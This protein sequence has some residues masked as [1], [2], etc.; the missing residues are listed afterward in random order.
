MGE[1]VAP[2]RG[3]AAIGEFIADRLRTLGIGTAGFLITPSKAMP[4]I[5]LEAAG[6]LAGPDY[7]F[8]GSFSGGL[9][10]ELIVTH[11]T[12]AK[13]EQAASEAMAVIMRHYPASEFGEP[14]SLEP[15]IFG[16]RL[17]LEWLQWY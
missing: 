4:L 15:G 17:S 6:S 11:E 1:P 8:E 5:V 10:W 9:R 16:R 13:A 3:R 12:T 2:L 14:V 7:G